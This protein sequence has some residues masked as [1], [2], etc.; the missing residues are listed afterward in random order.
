MGVYSF[1]SVVAA[2]TGPGGS[3]NLAAGAAAA[4]EGL[5]V[6][7]VGD[8]NKMDI[9]AD[10]AGM[11]SLIASEARTATINLLKTS[12]VNAQLQQMYN[13]QTINP[14]FHG[15]NVITVRDTVRGDAITLVQVAFKKQP[16]LVYAEEGDMLAWT[17][18]AVYA[19]TILGTGTPEI[20]A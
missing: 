7:A 2:I 1:L 13:L 10:G 5:T 4:K 19:D 6:E 14:I 18:D 16:K 8:K 9:G 17:F 3:I 11:H 12:P 20:Q 15:L